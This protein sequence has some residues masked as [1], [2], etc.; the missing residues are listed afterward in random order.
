MKLLGGPLNALK[1]FAQRRETTWSIALGGLG[2]F[3]MRIF[4][5]FRVKSPVLSF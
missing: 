2:S 4:T 3:G 1:V 5:G